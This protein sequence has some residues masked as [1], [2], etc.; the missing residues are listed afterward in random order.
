MK[1]NRSKS[2]ALALVVILVLSSGTMLFGSENSEAAGSGTKTDPYSGN[3][4]MEITSLKEKYFYEGTT[5][6]VVQWPGGHC[7][8]VSVTFGSGLNIQNNTTA[9]GTLN[10]IGTF[11]FTVYWTEFGVTE[12]IRFYVVEIITY[13]GG[14]TSNDPYSGSIRLEVPDLKEKYFYKGTSLELLQWPGGGCYY[15]SVT[16]ESGIII[17]S[18]TTASGILDTA[19]IFF[20]IVDWH[21]GGQERIRFYVV[22]EEPLTITSIPYT[23]VATGNK[24]TYTPT[25]SETGPKTL[26]VSGAF[27]LME[28]NGKIYGTAPIITGE[29]EEF[30]ITVSVMSNGRIGEQNFAL[31]VY[32]EIQYDNIPSPSMNVTHT[33]GNTYEFD[34]SGSQDYVSLKWN[35][36][37]GLEVYAKTFQYDFSDGIYTISLT[38]EN[39]VGKR[40]IYRDTEVGTCEIISPSIT[41]ATLDTYFEYEA[42]ANYSGY[43]FYVQD[44]Q[45][46]PEGLT[47]VQ[48]GNLQFIRGVPLV[49]PGTYTITM[50]ARHFAHTDRTFTVMDLRII[51]E[52]FRVAISHQERVYTNTDLTI[53]VDTNSNCNVRVAGLNSYEDSWTWDPVSKNVYIQFG[54]A[55]IK[56]V[57]VIFESQYGLYSIT[58]NISVEVRGNEDKIVVN[59]V[60]IGM[61]AVLIYISS[62]NIEL[63]GDYND[64][65]NA[66]SLLA[67]ITPMPAIGTIV[68]VIDTTYGYIVDELEEKNING[69]GVIWAWMVKNMIPM[70]LGIYSQ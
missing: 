19:G 13:E 7:R 6:N 41:F 12:T 56:N 70:H 62:E 55:G 69:Q 67:S 31:T 17:H 68:S 5:L 18:L 32:R 43:L 24:W 65:Y 39:N 14:G 44:G 34:G 51:V 9:S 25:V 8:L 50:E 47:L 58:K 48:E 15:R 16:S 11:Q 52:E 30:D 40:S 37:N 33:G 23:N 26:S 1:G 36:G 21:D 20:L 57:T 38:A 45:T 4:T 61:Y 29:S 53:A 27:W 35:L 64:L 10:T 54:K 60:D 63:I 42:K 49:S 3:I 28:S 59:P 66:V 22:E 2:I 46:L